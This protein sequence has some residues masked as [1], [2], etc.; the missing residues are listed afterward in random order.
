MANYVQDLLFLFHVQ[1]QNNP[2]SSRVNQSINLKISS[3]KLFHCISIPLSHKVQR[4]VHTS[5]I[6]F[7][8]LPTTKYATWHPA[9][10]VQRAIVCLFAQFAN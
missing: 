2:F 5:V 10:R 3:N 9:I 6:K 4:I 7:T 8:Q 1:T